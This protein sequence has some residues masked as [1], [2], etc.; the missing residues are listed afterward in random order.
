MKLNTDMLSKLPFALRVEIEENAQRK[1]LT[2]SELA[3]E[4]R[5]PCGTAQVQNSRHAR[6]DLKETKA[7]SA[8]D[9]AQVAAEA[10]AC[11]QDRQAVQRER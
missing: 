6:T 1:P 5:H 8:K 7:T 11:H 9:F 4:Q 3:L 2:Q 10:K